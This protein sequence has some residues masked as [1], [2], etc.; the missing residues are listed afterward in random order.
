M[1]C[2]IIIKKTRQLYYWSFRFYF[3]GFYCG[4][5]VGASHSHSDHIHTSSSGTNVP[6]TF[7]LFNCSS[8]FNSLALS[9]P[10]QGSPGFIGD[11]VS[12]SPCLFEVACSYI[13]VL[14]RRISS[15]FLPLPLSLSLSLIPCFTHDSPFCQLGARGGQY[16][17]TLYLF[18][19]FQHS[20]TPMRTWS[21]SHVNDNGWCL[22]LTSTEK[23]SFT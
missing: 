2:K 4:T 17:L 9:S 5:V 7:P 13:T 20:C 12:P 14:P 6:L 21:H 15:L 18:H 23:H 1:P 3:L 8:L 11:G 16:L 19:P 22:N 10:S